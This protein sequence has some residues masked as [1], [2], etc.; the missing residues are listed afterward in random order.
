MTE[1]YQSIIKNNVWEIVP[2]PKRKDVVSSKW[3]YKIK[4]VVDGSIEKY[5]ERF[6]AHGFSQKEGIN[7]E[8]TFSPIYRYTSIRTIIALAAKMKWKLHHM[9]VKT[10]FLNGV[11][12]EEV[13]IEKPQGFEVEHIKT[14]VCRL[15]KDLYRLKQAPRAWYGRIESFLMS[16]GFTK[17]KDDSNLYLNVM[18]D[19]PVILL[20]YVDDLFLTGEEN[21]IT[22]CKKKLATEFEMKDLGLMHHFLGLEVWQSPKKIFLNQGKYA[23]EILKSFDMLECKSMNTPMKTKLNLLIDTL[24]EMV[25]VTLYRQIIG[26]LMYLTNTRLDICF[27]VNTLSQYL[28]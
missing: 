19:E 22:D 6:V 10:T 16:L 23:V 25:D 26:S 2:R 1:E 21:L 4:H 7:Y 12:E 24:L 8:E 3:L 11:I 20:L 17:S 18:N 15:K 5:K 13:Y 27:I 9:D 14:H 28:V